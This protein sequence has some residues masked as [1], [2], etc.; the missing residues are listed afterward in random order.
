MIVLENVSIAGARKVDQSRSSRE[1]HRH[2]ERE[3]VRGSD[4]DDFRRV[5]FRRPCDRDS[6]P[7]NRP[8]N[9]GRA[10]EAKDSASLVKSRIFDPGNLSAIYEG[11]RADH[12]CLLRASGN[13]DL[14]RMTART[15]VVT[16]I[17]CE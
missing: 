13:D 17:G 12:H 9:D 2:A 16:K 5:L 7:V 6:F 1:T 3:L 4:I 8:W 14:I 11:H 10:G 15:S